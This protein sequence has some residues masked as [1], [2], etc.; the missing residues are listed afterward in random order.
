MEVLQLLISGMANGCVY[1]LV[2]LG[3][4]LIYKATEAVNFAQGDFMMLGA[5]VTLGLVN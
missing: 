4:V 3:F 1:G 5:F 2:A